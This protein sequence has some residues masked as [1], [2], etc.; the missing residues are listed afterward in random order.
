[1]G[2]HDLRERPSAESAPPAAGHY[3]LDPQLIVKDDQ[4]SDTAHGDRTSLAV[5][6]QYARRIAG[7]SG[8]RNAD[9]DC[10]LEHG[11]AHCFVHREGAAGQRT[12]S[13]KTLSLIH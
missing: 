5:D 10:A 3:L 2:Y 1:M 12:V 13:D 11:S 9:R 7:R 8:G 4:V 6:A